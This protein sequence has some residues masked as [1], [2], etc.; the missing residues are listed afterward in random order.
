[1]ADP[2]L[3]AQKKRQ[4]LAGDVPSPTNP[5]A[6]CRFHTRCP[7]VQTLC[8]EQEPPLEP[9]GEGSVAACHFP[10]TGD[11]LAAGAGALAGGEEAG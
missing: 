6:A 7:K 4:I 10:L 3:A 8:R 2:R 9:K 1:V 5:P 11:E